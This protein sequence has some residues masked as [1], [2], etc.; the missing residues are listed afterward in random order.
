MLQMPVLREPC[1]RQS[2]NKCHWSPNP[3]CRPRSWI[4]WRWRGTKLE[5]TN[6]VLNFIFQS[7]NIFNAQCWKYID[8]FFNAHLFFLSP[9]L[10]LSFS[11]EYFSFFSYKYHKTDH[12]L[13][14]NHIYWH[15]VFYACININRYDDNTYILSPPQFCWTLRP[16]EWAAEL[17]LR[18]RWASHIGE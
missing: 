18:L 10:S 7:E 1:N 14:T 2:C 12:Y 17:S 15:F 11:I 8:L 9:F 4:G 3:T 6:N 16:R 13:K 5:K